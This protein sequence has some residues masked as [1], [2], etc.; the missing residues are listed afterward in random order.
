MKAIPHPV[1]GLFAA[2]LLSGCMSRPKPEPPPPTLADRI[3]QS[4]QLYADEASARQA[5]AER[6]R[7]GDALVKAGA[8]EQHEAEADL[9]KATRDR[10]R[11]EKELKK[12]QERLAKADKAIAQAKDAGLAGKK[13]AAD[14]ARQKAAAE[15]E[16]HA[17]YPDA[18]L[19][20]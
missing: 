1:A 14:G 16:F 20:H 12:Q 3:E 11:A 18:L 2:A 5:Y 13:K 10:T 15:A 7:K 6:W 9:K 17:A 19:D 8:R 4:A